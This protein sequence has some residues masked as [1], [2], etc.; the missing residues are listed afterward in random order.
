MNQVTHEKEASTGKC[1]GWGAFGLI[2]WAV[3]RAMLA[4][5]EIPHIDLIFNFLEVFS[6]FVLSYMFG[7]KVM[8][9]K[10]KATQMLGINGNGKGDG[11]DVKNGQN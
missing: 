1:M 10:S 9:L 3:R 4:K 5:E 11:A 2:V 8:L 6:L 7:H